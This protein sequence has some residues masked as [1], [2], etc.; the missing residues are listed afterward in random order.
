MAE[1][2]TEEQT[3]VNLAEKVEEAVQAAIAGERSRGR[4]LSG[5][6]AAIMTSAAFIAGLAGGWEAA[7]KLNDVPGLQIAETERNELEV[8]IKRTEDAM[9]EMRSKIL[10]I[11]QAA[12]D[13]DKSTIDVV[14][15]LAG[16]SAKRGK[17]KS[18]PAPAAATSAPSTAGAQVPKPEPK[19]PAKGTPPEAGKAGT[20]SGK[21]SG[22]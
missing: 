5:W 19:A 18:A 7:V 22:S 2:H 11:R 8:K 15:E 14:S 1:E 6:K 3:P 4:A 21:A 9:S 12:K 16:L 20:P 17:A 13:L 10:Q